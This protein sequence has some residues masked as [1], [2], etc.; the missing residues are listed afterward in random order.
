VLTID[1]ETTSPAV[2]RIRGL[3]IASHPGPCLAITAMV[4]VLSI[5]AAPHGVGPLL[6]APAILAGQLSVGWSNDAWD[7]ARDAAAGRTDKPV[8]RGDIS[9]RAVWIAAFG[10]LAAA[11][12]MSL[13]IGPAPLL[14]N[15]VLIGAAWAYN[16]VLKSTWASGLMY[17]AGFAPIPAFVTSTLPGHPLPN[18]PVT[19]AAG[20]LGLGNHFANVLPDLA[21]DEA[22]DVNGLPQ[23]VAARWGAVAVRV[24]A[25]VL[26][27]AATVLLLLAANPARRWVAAAGLAA[28]CTVAM[29]GF[30]SSGK[31]PFASALGIAGI[32]VVLFAAGSETLT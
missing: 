22:A 25:L 24:A 13:A 11:L 12:V 5:Q 6:V 28:A 7:A 1:N 14:V 31:V 30:R 20:A 8:A 10:S 27:L 26:L 15:A 19:A 9:V 21:G 18:W 23:I 16:A 17:I 2:R 3:I 32:N 4:T 29:I